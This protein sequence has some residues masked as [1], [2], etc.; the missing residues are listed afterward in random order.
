M[1]ILKQLYQGNIRSQDDTTLVGDRYEE[2]LNE[3]TALYVAFEVSL[4]EELELFE[5]F[6]MINADVSELNQENS[7]RKGFMVCINLYE[8]RRYKD[9]IWL[10]LLI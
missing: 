3:I 5:D 8:G 7:F 2:A 4:T 10:V 1:S 6:K 9:F